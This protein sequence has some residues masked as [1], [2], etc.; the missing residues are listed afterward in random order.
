MTS[1][2]RLRAE[3]LAALGAVCDGPCPAALAACLGLGTPPPPAD[4]A[5]VFLLQI[6]PYASVHLGGEG[7]LGGQAADRVG[8][9]WRTLG[10]APPN[11]PDHLALVLAGYARLSEEACSEGEQRRARAAG[12]AAA[13]LAW[14][15]LASWAPACLE[16]VRALG[17]PFYRAWAELLLEALVDE[18]AGLA[19]Q[20]PGAGVVPTPLRL[21][22]D[23]LS[24][25]PDR[26]ELVSGV[27]APVRSGVVVT[28]ADLAGACRELG[29]GLRQGERAYLLGAML[30]Q[31]PRATLGWLASHARSWSTRHGSLRAT[32]LEP[33]A[34]WWQGRAERTSEVLAALVDGQA[35]LR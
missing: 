29:L 11:P 34:S 35:A 3:L 33:V 14:D 15:H 4:H 12:R 10:L 19:D 7:M 17:H 13:V 16:A 20:G 26:T 2:L 30:D 32:A 25:G 5:E 9:F 23:P 6:H 22:P 31:S 1:R 8:G 28:R 24:A 21:A 27:L 18:M